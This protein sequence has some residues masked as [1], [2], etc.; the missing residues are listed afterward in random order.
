[1]I[2]LALKTRPVANQRELADAIG[3]RGATLTHHLSAVEAD[4]LLTRRR[5]PEN[6]RI[7]IVELTDDGETMFHQLRKA[8]Q[9][10]DET[11]RAGLSQGALRQFRDVLGQLEANV[12]V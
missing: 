1:M 3:I 10:F 4:G 8:A 7:H 6:R 9:R 12:K 2:L 5:D 11:L